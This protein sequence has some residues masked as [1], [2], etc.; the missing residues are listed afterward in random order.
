MVDIPADASTT[1]SITVGGTISDTLEVAGDHDWF[2]LNLTAG[3]AV[4][5][6]L[7]GLTL[8]DTYLRIYDSSGTM[9]YENDD[10]SSFTTDS[11]IS[12]AASYT[13]SY[14]IDVGSWQDRT[15]GTYQLSVSNY[16]APPAATLQQVADELKTGYWG[17]N[18][19]HH[20]NV[21]TGGTIT[22]NLTALT[23]EGQTLARA[24]LAT[25]TDVIGINFREVATGGQITFD[26]TDPGAATSGSWSN[27]ITTS[28][29]VNVG[30]D[31]LTNYGTSLTSYSFQTYI[32]EIGHA[33]GLGHAGDYNGDG[34]YPYDTSF[35]ND[36]WPMT[37]MSYFD[38][39]QSTYFANLGFTRNYVATPMMA[40]V[41]AATQ[42]YGA[43]T[44]TRVG[45][46]VYGPSWTTT[47]GTICLFD[48]AGNDTI[49]VSAFAG[50]QTVDL[51]P[52]TFSNVLGEVGNISIAPG[53]TIENAITGSGNDTI[54]GNDVANILSGGLGRDTLTG[55]AGND[56]FKDTIA[57]H[58]TDTITDFTAGD[59]L[60][61][62]DASAS[63]F[64]YSLTGRTLTFSG[65]SLTFGTSLTGTLVASV[66]ASGGVQLTLASATAPLTKPVANDFNG[67]GKSDVLFG[68]VS[69][70]ITDWLGQTGGTFTSNHQVASYILPAGWHV[71]ASGDF[72]GD[73]R[74]DLLLRNDNGSVTEW[75]GQ[76]NGGFSWNSTATYALASSWHVA[77]TGDF[78]GDGRADVLLRS[79]TG[80]ITNWLGQADGTFLSNHQTASYVLPAGWTTSAIGDFNGDGR[81]DLLLRNTDGM[82][83]EWLGQANGGFSWNS[84]ATYALATGWVVEGA[85]DVS[86]DG[87]ADLVLRNSATGTVTDWLGQADGTFVSNHLVATAALDAA[88]KVAQI[89]DYNGDG[90]ADLL[91]RNDNGQVAEW[92]GQANGAFTLNQNAIYSLD[93][94]WTVQPG[95][96][97][98]F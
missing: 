97:T 63:S 4:T 35:A 76:A 40:D 19:A 71:A 23:A 77:G 94:G 67:D 57:G 79:D 81:S 70:A 26:D 55:G 29:H 92:L 21:T 38:Q 60:L 54:T 5:V 49:D 36:G 61:F 50:S 14:Y 9:V 24:A 13:G 88:W 20:F 68:Q 34:R 39:R 58:N 27:G 6:N 45:D 86:G 7:N 42:M 16:V 51:R 75:L 15:A 90:R 28:A 31:W 80:Q 3:Q 52:A 84:A 33:L 25:W 82:V 10:A 85:G 64:T 69:G 65:G 66:A 46:T 72:N 73:A 78:N 89:G 22:V 32:H 62:T 44:T 74:A 41:L 93:S 11:K 43:S 47:M 98:I 2:R 30:T 8:N 91:L 83:T 37:V 96:H 59:V 95:L 56:I 87:R 18:D 48:S 17:P 12:F 1:A 53:V